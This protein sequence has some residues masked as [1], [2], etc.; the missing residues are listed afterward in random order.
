[1][2]QTRYVFVFRRRQEDK[3]RVWKKDDQLLDAST[4]EPHHRDEVGNQRGEGPRVRRIDVQV[5]EQF[6]NGAISHLKNCKS[7]STNILADV[8]QTNYQ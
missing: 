1:M 4:I 2:H 3:H 6:S 7:L 8:Y 5:A